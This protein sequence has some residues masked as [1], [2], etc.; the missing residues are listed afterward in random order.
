M[1]IYTDSDRNIN[2][3][4]GHCHGGSGGLGDLLNLTS[5]ERTGLVKLGPLRAEKAGCT[6][7][8]LQE[9]VNARLVD[10]GS[11]YFEAEWELTREEGK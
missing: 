8:Y 9:G 7:V 2:G 4:I 1:R 10:A 3:C 6:K 11:V 5:L